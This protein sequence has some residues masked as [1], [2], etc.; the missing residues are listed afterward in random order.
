MNPLNLK[1]R[2]LSNTCN[3]SQGSFDVNSTLKEL[4][5]EEYYKNFIVIYFVGSLLSVVCLFVIITTLLVQKPLRKHPAHLVLCRVFSDLIVSTA[6]ITFYLTHLNADILFK[7]KISDLQYTCRPFS[8]AIEF[9]MI[10]G[11]TWNLMFGV[12]LLLAVRRPFKLHGSYL[13]YY[14]TTVWTL[15]LLITILF[16]AIPKQ[17]W[18]SYGMS[19]FFHCWVNAV[20]LPEYIYTSTLI[21]F[22]PTFAIFCVG[23][24]IGIRVAYCLKKVSLFSPDFKEHLAKLSLGMLCV[25]GAE[26]LLTLVL[27][28]LNIIITKIFGSHC[29]YI[30]DFQIGL[31]YVYA[32]IHSCRG[33]IVLLAWTYSISIR[34]RRGRKKNDVQKKASTQ[35]KNRGTISKSRSSTSSNQ[36]RISTNNDERS[37]LVGKIESDEERELSE[38]MFNSELRRYT[39]VCINYSILDSATTAQSQV[40][41]LMQG[42]IQGQVSYSQFEVQ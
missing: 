30:E 8:A 38:Y 36:D 13:K 16:I 40:Q 18:Q 15:S 31:I 34:N 21:Y 26:W 37:P 2:N 28:M 33:C 11:Y 3:V 20:S 35:K 4:F 41:G 23:C 1:E 24:L 10:S 17:G 9:G 32:V 29:L 27:W 5:S 19:M 7:E 42:T 39:V 25:L 22:L 6:H 14:H 12:D